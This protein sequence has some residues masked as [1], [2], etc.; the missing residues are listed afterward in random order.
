MKYKLSNLTKCITKGTTPTTLGFKYTNTGVNFIK[1]ECLVNTPRLDLSVKSFISNECNENMKR[2]Q[3]KENDIL[4]SIAG[5]Y[6]GK[7]GI[8]T[9]DVLPANTNQAVGIIRCNENVNYKY[10]YY[11]LSCEKTNKIINSYNSQSAQPNINLTQ[12]GSLEINL[13]NLESQQHIVNTKLY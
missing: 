7:T 2:S 4:V 11:W 5:V 8:A 3:L 9:K 6:L 10:V 13:P 12:L 1:S